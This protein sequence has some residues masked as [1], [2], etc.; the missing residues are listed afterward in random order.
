[1]CCLAS[2]GSTAGQCGRIGQAVTLTVNAMR[3]CLLLT[4]IILLISARMM[5]Q[6]ITFSGRNVALEKVLNSIETQT[7]YVFFY[8]EA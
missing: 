7:A 5:A 8:N 4:A 1:M 3:I 6:T 2:D